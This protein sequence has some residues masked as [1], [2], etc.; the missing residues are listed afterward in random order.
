MNKKFLSRKFL[1][2][3][4]TIAF[5]ILGWITGQLEPVQAMKI[6]AGIVGG[7]LGIEGLIDFKATK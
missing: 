2:T 3:L 1:M 4:G 7:Y 6:I 5:A